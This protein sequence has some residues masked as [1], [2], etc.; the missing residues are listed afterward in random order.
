MQ[1]IRGIHNL[2][3]YHQ[4]CVLTVG[5]FDGVHRGHQKLLARLHEEGLQRNASVMVM[6]FEPQPLEFFYKKNAPARLTR[7]NEKVRL[8]ARSG[9]DW[10]L[11][12]RFN[13]DFSSYSPQNFIAEILVKK[14]NIQLL[15][16]GSD[17]QF[18]IHRSGNFPLLK[19]ASI[20]YGFDIINFKALFDSKNRIS[21]TAIR[22]A[23]SEDNFELA[24]R[25][26]GRPFSISGRVIHGDAL[27]RVIGF[28]TANLSLPRVVLPIAGVYIVH[29][30]GYNSRIL[31]G[32]A[33]IG[34]RPTFNLGIKQLEI[35][36]FDFSLDI[37]GKYL[38][39]VMLRKIRSEQRFHSI[40]ALKNQIK[41]DVATARNFFKN[42]D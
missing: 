21:S 15:I 9:V 39:V 34:V 28:P 18:G 6:I 24:Q 13:N 37:Y 5:N 42:Q 40:N 2:R 1:L 41:S 20:H 4:G 38:E 35:Y 7:L 32:I 30:Q 12:V 29:V 25:L 22:H 11:C 10:V 14:L 8:L 36:L 3:K 17:F 31:P 27:G 33:N 19:E 16:V 26:L 23:L